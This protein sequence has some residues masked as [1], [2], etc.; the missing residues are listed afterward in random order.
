[1]TLDP[2]DRRSVALWLLEQLHEGPR[3]V[4]DVAAAAEAVGISRPVLQ[5]AAQSLPIR[6][7]P[8][9][10]R[11]PWLWSL[12]AGDEQVLVRFHCPLQECPA[13]REGWLA[14]ERARPLFVAGLAAFQ[15]RGRIQ[16]IRPPDAEGHR[17]H[18]KS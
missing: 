6:R 7:G 5:R 1:M 4:R 8:Q 15:T 3:F 10:L 16:R 18:V 13:S 11:G 2:A 9:K 14:F 17:L 12:S